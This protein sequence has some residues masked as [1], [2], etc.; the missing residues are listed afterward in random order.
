MHRH[1]LY[2]H[3][4]FCETKC[5]YCDFYSVERLGRDTSPVIQGILKE[6]HGRVVEPAVSI[7]T[8]FVGGGTP[9]VLPPDDLGRLFDSLGKIAGNS[10]V[11]EFT[12]EANPATVDDRTMSILAANGVNR[13]SMGAQSWHPAELATLERLHRPDDIAPGVAKAR[14]WGCKRVNLDLIFGIPGQTLASWQESLR[15]TIELDVDHIACYGL[16]YERGTRMTAQLHAGRIA[17]CDEDLEMEMYRTAIEQLA[18]A[19]YEQYEISNFAKPGQPCLHNLIYWRNESYLGVGPSA[20]GF[21]NG[22]R[23]KNVADI[24]RYVQAM[25]DRGEAVLESELVTETSLAGEMLFMQLRLNEGIDVGRFRERT[26]MDPRKVF[27]RSLERFITAGQVS[28]DGDRLALTPAGRMVADSIIA[29]LY[30]ELH[31]VGV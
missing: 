6:L 20:A 16:T 14:K 7:R 15:R 19:G 8:I 18:C 5:G 13:I 11:E 12:V 22:T 28:D 26:T 3:V 23:Y 1:G 27:G 9:T 30:S 31:G 2:V 21:V 25:R 17:P 29:E 24:G 4:P 10:D